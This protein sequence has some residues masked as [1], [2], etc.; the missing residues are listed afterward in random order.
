[1]TYTTK[2]PAASN[3]PNHNGCNLSTKEETQWPA[4]D[5]NNEYCGEIHR[6]AAW[7][8]PARVHKSLG[9]PDNLDLYLTS[10]G[11]WVPTREIAEHFINM[12]PAQSLIVKGATLS[13][14]VP[15]QWA[16][17]NG[18]PSTHDDYRVFRTAAGG[19]DAEEACARQLVG[20]G[21]EF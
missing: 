18:N 3:I 13:F 21:N 11:H 10:N 14:F 12:P 8:V 15:P 17:E 9:L 16:E 5:Q 6:I 4:F 7:A 2:N 19:W 1:M 20:A